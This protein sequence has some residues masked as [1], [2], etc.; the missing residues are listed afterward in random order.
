MFTCLKNWCS[1]RNE[2]DRVRQVSWISPV[3]LSGKFAELI[4]LEAFHESALQEAAA[5]GELWKLWFTSV[6]S[7]AYTAAY[8]DAALAE[9]AAGHSLPFVVRRIADGKIVGCTRYCF[10]HAEHR[11]L[12]IGYTWYAA[13]AQRTAINTECKLLLLQHAFEAR[14]A[15]AVEFCTH[16]FNLRSRA[17][18]ERLGAKLDGILRNHRIMRDGTLRDTCVYSIIAGEW[19]AVK[20]HLKYQIETPRQ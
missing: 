17:A 11:R 1:C 12:E 14:D 2:T 4:P 8:I 10:I 3:T 19:P 20:A 13:G 16:F 15:I 9:R 5:D 18:I 7:P 6:P